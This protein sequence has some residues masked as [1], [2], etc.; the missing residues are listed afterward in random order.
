MMVFLLLTGNSGSTGVPTDAVTILICVCTPDIDTGQKS[1]TYVFLRMCTHWHLLL[2][3]IR[4]FP[5]GNT[6]I[7][8]G[9]GAHVALCQY[10][11]LSLVLQVK[12][13]AVLQSKPGIKFS[14]PPHQKS[15]HLAI[16][17]GA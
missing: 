10:T 16:L 15:V 7:D 14:F 13:C 4:H 9:I 6:N 3:A 11:G 1:H 12:H 17:M 2:G 8:T 5:G